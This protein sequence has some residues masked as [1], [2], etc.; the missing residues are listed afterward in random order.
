MNWISLVNNGNY[1]KVDESGFSLINFLENNAETL[2]FS[3]S[4]SFSKEIENNLVIDKSIELEDIYCYHV[5]CNIDTNCKILKDTEIYQDKWDEF[6]DVDYRVFRP[7]FLFLKCIC[8]LG[9]G[10]GSLLP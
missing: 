7:S 2:S 9:H 6:F 4:F 3:T 10:S 5:I 8:N 1:S